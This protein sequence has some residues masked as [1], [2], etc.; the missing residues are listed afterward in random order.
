[1]LWWWL[2]TRAYGWV[3]ADLSSKRQLV[4]EADLYVVRK[5]GHAATETWIS[6]IACDALA[7]TCA[8]LQHSRKEPSA[9]CYSSVRDL[10]SNVHYTG[11]SDLLRASF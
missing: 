11:L 10:D 9:L 6:W 4:R 1:M 2:Y 5:M 3:A 8:W 7:Q